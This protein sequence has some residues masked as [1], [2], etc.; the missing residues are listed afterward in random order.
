MEAFGN[1]SWPH[2][3]GFIVTIGILLAGWRLIRPVSF[4]RFFGR[5]RDW[6]NR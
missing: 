5:V 3:F 4:G 2:V 6:L 1:I